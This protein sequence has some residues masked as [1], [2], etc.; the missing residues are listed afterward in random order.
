MRNFFFCCQ[1][2]WVTEFVSHYHFPLPIYSYRQC[3]TKLLRHS[4]IKGNWL[5]PGE[6]S[7]FTSP[8]AEKIGK[9]QHLHGAVHYAQISTG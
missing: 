8:I 7:S 9:I 6:T 1:Q 5:Y 4:L 2:I 3:L